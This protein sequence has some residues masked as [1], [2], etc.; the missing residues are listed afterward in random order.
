[1]IQMRQTS[2]KQS[3]NGG[4]ERPKPLVVLG[5]RGYRGSNIL[6]IRRMWRYL[7]AKAPAKWFWM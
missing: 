2:D 3:I 1:M 7:Y 5:Y 4:E 6:L